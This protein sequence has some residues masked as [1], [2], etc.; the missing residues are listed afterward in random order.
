MEEVQ[1]PPLEEQLRFK[2]SYVVTNRRMLSGEKLLV[3]LVNG[4]YN[5]CTIN[6]WRFMTGSKDCSMDEIH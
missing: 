5:L 3:N 1:A 2:V 4:K 6:E